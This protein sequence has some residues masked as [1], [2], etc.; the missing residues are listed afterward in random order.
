[1]LKPVINQSVQKSPSV[2][3]TENDIKPVEK[4][5]EK[6]LTVKI[7]PKKVLFNT[8]LSGLKGYEEIRK[9]A[10][11]DLK[12]EEFINDCQEVL[13]Y[14]KSKQT[15]KYDHKTLLFCMELAEN[16]FYKSKSGDT[17]LSVVLELMKP[18]YDDNEELLKNQIELL[19]HKVKKSS[20]LGRYV[21]KGAVFL[22]QVLSFCLGK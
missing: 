4:E 1:M 9:Q 15:D 3:I 11:Y 16:Y 6:G 21:N 7:V 13:K 22:C 20:L 8:Q 10:K 5:T 17:K 12:R 19:L 14:F 18:Y 2:I